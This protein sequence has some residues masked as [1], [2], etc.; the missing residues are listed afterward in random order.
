M[1]QAVSSV[2]CHTGLEMCAEMCCHKNWLDFLAY[3]VKSNM[4]HKNRLH[5]TFSVCCRNKE[6]SIELYSIIS[7]NWRG[8]LL[9]RPCY[10]TDNKL[11]AAHSCV[12][13]GVH[14]TGWPTAAVLLLCHISRDRLIVHIISGALV[15]MRLFL[16]AALCILKANT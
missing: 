7:L 8:W 16:R 2:Y 6:N 15:G 5:W 14:G 13:G 3:I 4:P 1:M 10:S 9:G 11:D 12:W